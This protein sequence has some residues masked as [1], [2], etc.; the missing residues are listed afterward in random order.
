MS[1]GALEML[2]AAAFA[3]DSGPYRGPENNGI[4]S[5]TG[6]LRRWPDGGPKLLWKQPLEGPGFSSVTVT[7]GK[8]Y[9]TSGGYSNLYVFSL[10]GQGL[11]KTPVGPAPFKRFGGGSRSTTL[12]RGDVAVTTTAMGGVWAVDLAR[13][14]LRWKFD[15]SR[16]WGEDLAQAGWGYCESPTWYGGNLILGSTATRPEDPLLMAFEIDTG[17]M[18]W[19]TGWG[20]PTSPDHHYQSPSGSAI[21]FDH[22]G[23]RLVAFSAHSYL[24][25]VDARTGTLLWQIK[26]RGPHHMTPVYNDGL[27]LWNWNNGWTRDEG[28]EKRCGLQMLR[29]SPDGSSY[30]VLWTR[31]DYM[32][33]WSHAV[34]LDGRLY[35]YGDPDATLE[36]PGAA[37]ETAPARRGG[38]RKKG[39]FL[40]LDAATGAVLA[41]QPV[42]EKFTAP[43]HVVSA[44]GLIFFLELLRPAAGQ[45]PVPRLVMFEPT[46]D[47][48]VKTGEVDPPVDERDL[49]VKEVEWQGRTP[50]VIAEGRLFVRY[51]SIFAYDVRAEAPSRGWRQDGAGVAVEAFPP[52]RWSDKHNLRWSANLPDTPAAPPVVSA[53]RAFV[54]CRS[55]QL[56]CVAADS[57]KLLWRQALPADG[58]DDDAARPPTP[59][60]T[61]DRVY[62]VRR[63]GTVIALRHDGSRVW[64]AKAAPAKQR[65]MASPVLAGRA[66]VVQGRELLGLD[67]RNGQ[68]LWRKPI[69]DDRPYA[70]PVRVRLRG[71][72]LIVTGWGTIVRA[73]DGTA[74]AE[75]L[76][77]L[78]RLSPAAAGR[79]VFLWQ[80]AGDGEPGS[81]VVALRLPDKP[82]E[83]MKP[84]TRW[85]R[86]LPDFTP[87]CSP[88]ATAGTLYGLAANGT[89]L[90]LDAATGR[91]SSTRRLWQGPSPGTAAP[92]P[93]AL[94][95]AGKWVYALSG[96]VTH[97]L[98]AGPRPEQVWSYVVDRGAGE[99]GFWKDRQYMAA[100]R[101]LY[102]LA[103]PTPQEPVGPGVVTPG[104]LPASVDTAGLPVQ[105]FRHDKMP[106]EWLFCGPIP[107]RSFDQDH[108]APLG[109]RR[110]AVPA[111]GGEV[112][113]N[114]VKV[115]FRKLQDAH[116]W[117]EAK[118]TAGMRCIDLTACLDGQRR[119]TGYFYT[120][121]RNDTPRYARFMLHTP[122]GWAWNPAER[123]K[124]RMWIGGQAVTDR[125]VVR[126]ERG[127][128]PVMIE[129]TLGGIGARDKV[130]IA[131]RLQDVTEETAPLAAAHEAALAGWRTYAATAQ[132]VPVLG[133]DGIR[134]IPPVA[135][136]AATA[137]APQ[138]PRTP[139]LP[140]VSPDGLALRFVTVPD[141]PYEMQATEVTQHQWRLVMGTE[142][143][144]DRALTAVGPDRPA[145]HV[146]WHDA[147]RFAE[148][149][150]C[151]DG[152]YRYR[153]P[154]EAEWRHVALAGAQGEWCFGADKA[155]LKEYAW[156][157][158]NAE[159]GEFAHPVAR[160]RPNAWGLYD[161]HG[162][163]WEWCGDDLGRRRIAKGGAWF[164]VD[165]FCSLLKSPPY[166][167]AFRSNAV[168]FR[169]LR[170][171]APAKP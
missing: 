162:N 146:S 41:R 95:A 8:V 65:P 171:P 56:A 93:P 36:R 102:C 22:N 74:V 12:V 68:V 69:P 92:A 52:I 66:L 76:P 114:G 135:A 23:R 170:E 18:V 123:L 31:W 62:V 88:L 133:P 90:A 115:V 100:G 26:N 50:P 94:V 47:G 86:T 149:L 97:V 118:R 108:L 28:E 48:L 11:M 27:L 161:V 60:V 139:P 157:R 105:P 103:G 81:T 39:E 151:L 168:G 155:R 37:A 16:D 10:D 7:D 128:Y 77:A 137:P 154:A 101:R 72:D 70:A 46:A 159:Q 9:A 138:P 14:A 82:S 152:K 165:W 109:G 17:E 111:L 4:Y 141:R 153:L 43:G 25:C 71:Q 1:L 63:D 107:H 96:S 169:L 53:D 64:T 55:G 120:V 73:D 158:D 117:A 38:R 145:V 166:G 164:S 13:Q 75:H 40:C 126:L 148:R 112:A 127:L 122:G 87:A 29:L 33:D 19:G 163:V 59:V 150:S 30:K 104:A 6:I 130:W 85:R 44:D 116:W 144:K 160:L 78:L 24:V 34:I 99:P 21:C 32:M 83:T 125:S 57:G 20:E 89:L 121:V 129:A 79:D 45:V 35:L 67:L 51:G 136:V 98:Q 119:S 143:W 84:L 132:A 91:T 142:P 3:A 134:R 54:L 167:P 49:A 106:T 113:A 156:F 15:V 140:A 80:P 124:P 110:A 58:G 131:P 61:P 2:C 5:E 42:S 147:V